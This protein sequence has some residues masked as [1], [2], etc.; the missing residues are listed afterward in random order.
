[1]NKQLFDNVIERMTTSLDKNGNHLNMNSI[2]IF[3]N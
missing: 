2:S 3:N 1:M